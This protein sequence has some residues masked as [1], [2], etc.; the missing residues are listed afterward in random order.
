M[1]RPEIPRDPIKDYELIHNKSMRKMMSLGI[2]RGIIEILADQDYT[3]AVLEL[4]SSCETQRRNGTPT[5]LI[6]ELAIGFISRLDAQLYED[7]L[8]VQEIL[9]PEMGTG[10]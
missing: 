3:D 10:L 5:F 7:A 2:A 4:A 9:R 1:T 8:V 6:D